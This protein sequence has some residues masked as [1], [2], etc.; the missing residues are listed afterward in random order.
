MA[1]YVSVTRAR[2]TNRC[3]GKTRPHFTHCQATSPWDLNTDPYKQSPAKVALLYV[4]AFHLLTWPSYFMG[5]EAAKIL[6]DPLTSINF[7]YNTKIAQ[8]G[9]PLPCSA[10]CPFPNRDS[11]SPLKTSHSR[12]KLLSRLPTQPTPSSLSPITSS[13]FAT[14]TRNQHRDYPS[15]QPHDKQP[16]QNVGPHYSDS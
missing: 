2:L 1:T 13:S 7:T 16:P 9:A 4:C 11:V 10:P 12:Q 5:L 14:P 15:H 8:N 6:A 3:E